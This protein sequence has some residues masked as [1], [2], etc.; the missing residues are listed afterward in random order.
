MHLDYIIRLDAVDDRYPGGRN[1]L[2]NEYRDQVG[3]TV[4]FDDDLIILHP[5]DGVRG[6]RSF[7]N[8]FE[9]RGLVLFNMVRKTRYACDRVYHSQSTGWSEPCDWLGINEWDLTVWFWK[10]DYWMLNPINCEKR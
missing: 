4:H 2:F 5:V 7:D 8:Y 1:A 3:K 6:L 10:E 9:E